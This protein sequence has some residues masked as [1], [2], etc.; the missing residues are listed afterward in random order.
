VQQQSTPSDDGIAVRTTPPPRDFLADCL[1]EWPAAHALL[2]AIECR[3]LWHY[4]LEPPILD[5]GCG[6]GTLAGFVFTSPLQVG[7][8]VNAREVRQAKFSPVY[9][10]VLA[11]SANRLPFPDAFFGSVFSNCVLEHIDGLDAA[12]AEI[13]RV[14]KPGGVLLTTVPTPRWESDGPLPF[15]RRLGLHGL[16]D[17]LS[18]GLKRLWHHVTVEDRPAWQSRLAS[19]QL[20]LEVWEPYM[21]PAAYAAYARFLP[22]A[23]CSFVLRRLTG[24]W[25]VS[26]RLRRLFVPLLCRFLKKAYL[27]EDS[28]GACALLAARKDG[29]FP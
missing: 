28:T 11:A 12:L 18:A 8:D 16:S 2:R 10:H 20:S 5:I 24:R 1:K 13:C 15:L 26:K 19:A 22:F 6:D 3:K 21:V 23:L 14:L 9:R 4:P 27:A 17:R 25:L 29:H 7:M